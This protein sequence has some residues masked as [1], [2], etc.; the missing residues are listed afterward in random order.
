MK[1]KLALFFIC[2]VGAPLPRSWAAETSPS[3]SLEDYLKRLR[4][5]PIKFRINDRGEPLMEGEIGAGKKRV[6]LLDTGWGMT[7]LDKD[8]AAGFKTLGEMGVVL[9]D[10]L[11]GRLTN[12]AIVLIDKLVLGRAQFLNQPARLEK[13][14]AD[15]VRIRYDAVLGCDFFFRNFCLIDCAAR[16]LYVRSA[17]PSGGESKALAE[18][19]RRSGLVEVPLE[20]MPCLT[21]EAK[22]NSRPAH[23]IL[24]TG[25]EFTCLDE[26]QLRPLGLSTVKE[27]APHTGTRIPGE[28]GGLLIGVGKIG[29]HKL[30]VTTLATLEIGPKQWK[31]IHVGVAN[32]KAWGILQP[33]TASEDPEGVLGL[34][35]LAEQ[36]ALI[37]FASRKLWLRR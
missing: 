8:S 14:E 21:V 29:A 17:E 28:V 20:A 23:L 19:L 10:T 25:S 33:G 26:S 7:T 35:L 2:I 32:L 5:E 6:L 4:Y 34:R 3:T 9:E 11:L 15:F 37:D 18:S 36:G 16:R 30:R 22:A 1:L 13:L 12:P 24:D 27:D 31:N